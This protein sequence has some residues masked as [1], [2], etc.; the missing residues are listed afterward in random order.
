MVNTINDNI[1]NNNEFS[2][3]V[4]S[5]SRNDKNA[6][7]DD[8]KFIPLFDYNNL[9]N[10]QWEKEDSMNFNLEEAHK[11]LDLILKSDIRH[12]PFIPN[13]Y[14]MMGMNK[15]NTNDSNDNTQ[16]QHGSFKPG[17]NYGPKFNPQFNHPYPHY[18]YYPFNNYPYYNVPPYYYPNQYL[19]NNINPLALLL[20]SS[21][22]R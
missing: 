19:P 18:P 15:P 16:R 21:L 1:D 14:Y 5:Y 6:S 17:P 10:V 20:F 9:N 12:M 3:E 22:Y 4:N 11:C 2:S 8:M 7:Q 13:P